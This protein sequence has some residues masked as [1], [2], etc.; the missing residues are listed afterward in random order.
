MQNHNHQEWSRRMK[1]L[2]ERMTKYDKSAATYL[3]QWY[4]KLKPN[5][6]LI[7]L[8]KE[9]DVKVT[10]KVDALMKQVGNEVGQ[11]ADEGANGD[12][13]RVLLYSHRD[14][15]INSQ[16]NSTEEIFLAL[17]DCVREVDELNINNLSRTVDFPPLLIKG[18]PE[19]N[20][21]EKKK[22]S[23]RIIIINTS[24]KTFSNKVGLQVGDDFDLYDKIK[25][26]P[27]W[28]YPGLNPLVTAGFWAKVGQRA[29]IFG[30]FGGRS[31]SVDVASFMGVNVFWWDAPWLEVAAREPEALRAYG[32]KPDDLVGWSIQ[33]MQ[34]GAIKPTTPEKA[35]EDLRPLQ[36]VRKYS[37][38]VPT[39]LDEYGLQ[40]Q[41]EKEDAMKWKDFLK[42]PLVSPG[43]T[44]SM[45][46]LTQA[47]TFS[48]GTDLPMSFQSL[49]TETANY[50]G[51][52]HNQLAQCLRCLQLA[53]V[54]WAG[55]PEL[56]F[57]VIAHDNTPQWTGMRPRTLKNWLNG[58][59]QHHFAARPAPVAGA[60][61]PPLDIGTY[62]P[63][64]GDETGPTRAS[65]DKKHK[66]NP[67][68]FVRSLPMT[69]EVS[70]RAMLWPKVGEPTYENW[71][72]WKS[73][74]AR[75][76]YIT[77][78]TTVNQNN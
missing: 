66:R 27:N 62:R 63:P 33:E 53:T 37:K 30:L 39:T 12:I 58:Q 45:T 41:R 67:W 77:E 48:V 25:L 60:T 21:F 3:K 11:N 70:D 64:E 59:I 23:T 65:S 14:H 68:W 4:K 54:S 51:E 13:A 16:T 26:W 22:Y 9:I 46:N 28:V 6:P 35:A 57:A 8:Q 44:S 15:H 42:K 5:E 18:R 24:D 73:V 31:G 19:V 55:L 2:R 10:E 36:R 34:Q 72:Y 7:D 75:D 52:K 78:L 76:S 29:D 56:Q 1:T 38:D 74:C 71:A 43:T 69:G 32:L 49:K 17:R 61:S 50:I 40:L 20:P 47:T